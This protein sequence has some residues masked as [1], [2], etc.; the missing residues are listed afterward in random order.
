MHP[1][2]VTVWCGFRAGGINGP[3]FIKNEAGQEVTATGARYRGMIQF[4]LPIL[5]DI[6]GTNMWFQQDSATCHTA[7]ETIQLL[8]ESCNVSCR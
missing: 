3:Y 6:D 5:N 8:H 2:R 7:S 4:L 1:Q